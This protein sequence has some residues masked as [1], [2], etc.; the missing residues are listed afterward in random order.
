MLRLAVTA[1][2]TFVAFVGPGLCCCTAVRLA[3]E[4]QCRQGG[5]AE[6]RSQACCRRSSSD[7]DGQRPS[8]N[9]RPPHCPC[10]EHRTISGALLADAGQTVQPNKWENAFGFLPLWVAACDAVDSVD[11][12]RLSV[13]APGDDG[14]LFGRD[15]L[16]AL[17]LLRC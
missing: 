2:L 3:D 15:I 6:R 1:Y 16:R 9:E 5:Q 10:D 8:Q 7:D 17:H 11:G 4:M 12:T 13:P 14:A